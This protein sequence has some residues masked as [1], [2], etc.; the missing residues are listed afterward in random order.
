MITPI[1]RIMHPLTAGGT[2][3]KRT[4][5]STYPMSQSAT[6]QPKKSLS[7]DQVVI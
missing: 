2:T 6:P 1:G 3:K 5:P 7:S 4:I